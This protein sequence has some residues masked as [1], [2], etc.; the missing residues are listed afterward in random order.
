VALLFLYIKERLVVLI[1]LALPK[2]REYSSSAATA[3]AIHLPIFLI[4]IFF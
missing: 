3:S 4:L 2:N 1:M